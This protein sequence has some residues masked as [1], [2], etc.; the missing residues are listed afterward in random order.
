MR[1]IKISYSWISA[2]DT[3]LSMKADNERRKG[4]WGHL[5]VGGKAQPGANVGPLNELIYVL[6]AIVRK[7]R[8][9]TGVTGSP[10]SVFARPYVGGPTSVD[11]LPQP[12]VDT[13]D[14]AVA[15]RSERPCCSIMLV[16][17]GGFKSS[18]MGAGYR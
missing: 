11:E 12:H 14:D 9:I 8:G 17:E 5:V 3:F 18:G 1:G 7:N 10:V 15:G 13:L 16:L 6:T 4:R 2:L